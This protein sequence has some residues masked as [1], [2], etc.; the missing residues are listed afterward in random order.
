MHIMYS[1]I[2]CKRVLTEEMIAYDKA[3]LQI[4]FKFEHDSSSSITN[5]LLS[6]NN[7]TAT[8]FDDFVFQAAVPKVN[9]Y[10]LIFIFLDISW[11]SI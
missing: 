6:A 2:P 3:G 10:K 9:K 8:N 7:S 4:Y 1:F 11:K 5:I